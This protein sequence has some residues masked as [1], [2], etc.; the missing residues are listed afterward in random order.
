MTENTVLYTPAAMLAPIFLWDYVFNLSIPVLLSHVLD[1][2]LVLLKCR[3]G[4]T[5]AACCSRTS[6]PALRNTESSHC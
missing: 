2:H 5:W 6:A 3:E 1:K 4:G